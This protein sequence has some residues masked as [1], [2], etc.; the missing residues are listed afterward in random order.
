MLITRSI[1]SRPK[2]RS[3]VRRVF[4]LLILSHLYMN[5]RES[6][7]LTLLKKKCADVLPFIEHSVISWM[8]LVYYL[9]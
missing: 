1:P 7:M 9:I 5:A 8:L 2:G 3:L 4:C 6:E